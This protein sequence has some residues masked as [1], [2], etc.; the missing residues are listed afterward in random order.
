MKDSEVVRN[1]LKVN[2]D[3]MTLKC[4]NEGLTLDEQE[5]LSLLIQELSRRTKGPRP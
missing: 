5:T 1:A 4:Y 2:I 3:F